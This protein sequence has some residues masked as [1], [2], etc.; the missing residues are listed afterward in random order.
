MFSYIVERWQD[1]KS[2]A[3]TTCYNAA[4]L[5]GHQSAKRL[6]IPSFM[7]LDGS[8][9]IQV[10]PVTFVFVVAGLMNV[11]IFMSVISMETVHGHRMSHAYSF[12][13]TPGALYPYDQ[14]YHGHSGIGCGCGS[15][16]PE[17]NAASNTPPRPRRSDKKG[18]HA[19]M[20][21]PFL[22]LGHHREPV[23]SLP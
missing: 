18:S 20:R 1:E 7:M 2:Q 11:P 6:L 13:D 8:I 4:A 3:I 10:S 19:C 21:V 15:N 23:E 12:R 9:A 5:L 22:C 17:A 16:D 14:E